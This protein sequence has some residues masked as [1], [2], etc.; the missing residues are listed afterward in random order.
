MTNLLLNL[1]F[2]S[3]P[4]YLACLSI[5]IFPPKAKVTEKTKKKR[6][7]L[8]RAIITKNNINKH[9]ALSFNVGV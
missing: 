8:T 4:T 7:K 1:K 9:V 6:K 3:V 5:T 2:E